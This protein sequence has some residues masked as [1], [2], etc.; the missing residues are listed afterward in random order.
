MLYEVI[1]KAILCEYFKSDNRQTRRRSFFTPEAVLVPLVG[2]LFDAPILA[3]PLYLLALL[4]CGTI[5][6][7]ARNNFV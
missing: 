3:R 4:S 5:G 2:L 6:F 1:T 7:A